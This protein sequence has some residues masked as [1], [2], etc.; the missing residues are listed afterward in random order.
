[1]A[2]DLPIEVARPKTVNVSAEVISV[3]RESMIVEV[4]GRFVIFFMR[5]GKKVSF[6]VWGVGEDNK[7]INYGLG[8]VDSPWDVDKL[9]LEDELKEVIKFY[10][11][12]WEY[13][14]QQR[15]AEIILKGKIKVVPKNVTDREVL[16]ETIA[17]KVLE[18]HTVRTFFVKYK[19]KEVELGVFC[20]DTERGTYVDCEARIKSEVEALVEF[21]ELKQKTTKWVITEALEKVKRRTW[22]EFEPEKHKLIFYNKVFDWDTFIATGDLHSSLSDP[23]PEQVITHWIPH[24]INLGLLGKAREGLERYIPPK[25]VDD[26]VEL[27]KV[28]APKSYRAFVDWVKEPDEGE[29]QA[30][31]KVALLLELIGYAL[32]PHEYPFHKAVLL[33]GEGANGKSTYLNLVRKILG[34]HNVASVNLRDMDPRTNR[35]AAAELYGKLANISAE[36]IES[37]GSF[38]PTLFKQ[39]TGEDLVTVERKFKDP[40]QTVNYAKMFFSTNRLPEVTENTYAFWRRWIVVEFPNQFPPDDTFFEKTFTE[41]EIEGVIVCSL[42]TFRLVKLRKGFTEQGAK[43]PKEEWMKRSNPVYRVVKAM[44]DEG[45]I[46]LDK[47]GWIEK[48]DLY[49]M[50]AN[51]VRKLSEEDEEIESVSHATFTKKIEEL[52]GVKSAQ[53][54]INNKKYNVYVGVRIKD[55]EKAR[56]LAGMLDTPT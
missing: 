7:I 20:Y 38:D 5:I 34:D 29:D 47:N 15:A 50:Y 48:K 32:Y 6:S 54:K 52:F 24:R 55:V 25:D 45:I 19:G 1:M 27:M 21:P 44:I 33:V 56:E 41:D 40:F 8:N 17:N 9:D 3:T 13:I 26:L 11:V 36:P 16:A 4:G 46:E 28:L 39:L 10:F 18:N 30:K 22:T 43:D 49:T 14:L 35:F 23:S 53:K 2:E 42:Y 37:R 51:Y 12:N 31:P